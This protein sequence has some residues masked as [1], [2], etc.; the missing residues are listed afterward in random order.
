[1]NRRIILS[2]GARADLNAAA[3]W[4]RQ[5]EI[6]L[7]RRFKAEVWSTLLRIARYPYSFV[8]DD[9]AV[10]RACMTRFPYY[11]YFRFDPD[12]VNVE[13]ISHQRRS[14]AVWK[15]RIE[16]FPETGND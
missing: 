14:D 15:D 9:A 12:Q 6:N 4:Y 16:E 2:P 5:K 1:M 8:R 11:I 7:S 10:R 13:A 3:R